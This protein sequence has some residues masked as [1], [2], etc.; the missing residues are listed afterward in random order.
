MLLE[1]SKKL[2]KFKDG[3]MMSEEREEFEKRIERLKENKNITLIQ[4]S[5]KQRKKGVI[6]K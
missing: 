4:E 3:K 2:Q 6:E 1:D 5:K